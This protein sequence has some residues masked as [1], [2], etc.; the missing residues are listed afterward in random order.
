MAAR[1]KNLIQMPRQFVAD[2]GPGRGTV[3]PNLARAV[4]VPR[5]DA[6]A[7]MAGAEGLAALGEGVSKIGEALQAKQQLDDIWAEHQVDLAM[8][9]RQNVINQEIANEPDNAKWQSIA[10]RNFNELGVEIQKIRMGGMARNAT[11]MKM[12]E[13][14]VRMMGAVQLE[15]IKDSKKKATQAGADKF[16]LAI[17]NKDRKAM[18]HT[19]RGMVGAGLWQQET[20]DLAIAKGEQKIKDETEREEV[21]RQWNTGLETI[22]AMGPQEALKIFE[23]DN[24]LYDPTTRAR[25]INAAQQAGR[26][27]VS[28]LSDDL[29]N[30][31]AGGAITVP[32]QIDEWQKDNPAV[33]PRM[34]EIAKD[35]LNRRNSAAEKTRIEEQGPEMASKLW[36]EV[37]SF[38]P[39]K[40]TNREQYFE[41][42][43]RIDQL[44][45]AM[46]APLRK[47][48]DDRQMNRM[49]DPPKNLQ[50]LSESI[51]N[52]MFRGQQFGLFK[53]TRDVKVPRADGGV[54]RVPDSN[55][56]N[57]WKQ[58]RWFDF[59]KEQ[60]ALEEKARVGG[61]VTRWLAMNPNADEKK[62]REFIYTATDDATLAGVLD[63]LDDAARHSIINQVPEMAPVAPDSE[64][65]SEDEAEDEDRT[66]GSGSPI[67]VTGDL[68]DEPAGGADDG[69][70]LLPMKAD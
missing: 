48:L 62:V 4:V 24:N 36:T 27:Q 66:Y 28:G 11:D 58:E 45:E 41:F 55:S 33:T 57:G 53:G 68:P 60:A 26:E 21:E 61:A 18:I 31:V 1:P 40:D 34:R 17:V 9:Q 22:R 39:K 25:L 37:D 14:R 59:R 69:T 35:Y 23:N 6:N 54:E 30:Q 44:P 56:P 8:M 5:L 50:D 12:Q 20:A 32:E 70:P 15:S 67:G 42:R 43:A 63:I 7:A 64:E 47:R 19:A 3:Q 2:P 51:L 52:S 49:P 38:D 29:E 13:A 65:V 46:R 10:E 16:E